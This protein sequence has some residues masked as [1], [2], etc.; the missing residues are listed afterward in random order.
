MEA[1]VFWLN[2]PSIHQAP[3]LRAAAALWPG[4]VVAV[5]EA[6][7][8][9]ARKSQGWQRPDFAPARLVVE[10]SRAQRRELVRQYATA[11]S[12]HIFS[13]LHAYPE[14]ARA[15]RQVSRSEALL[16]VFAEP[17]RHND[18]LKALLRRLRYAALALRWRRRLDFL[19]ATGELGVRWYTGQGFPAERAYPFGYFV[20][21]DRAKDSRQDLDDPWAGEPGETKL[22]FVGQLIPR[23]GVDLLLHALA[24]LSSRAWR[25]CFVGQ[26]TDS[27]RLTTLADDLGL[28]A[29]VHWQGSLPNDAVRAW[30][31]EADTLILPSRYDGWGAVVNEALALGTPV[32]VSDAC[33]AADLVGDPR[34]GR[35]FQAG[36]VDSLCE[37]LQDVL[38]S[39][40]LSAQ[41]RAAI[42][43]WALGAIAPEAAARYLLAIIAHVQARGA[44]PVAPWRGV[45]SPTPL[46][47]GDEVLVRRE[48]RE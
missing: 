46:A 45:P 40:G 28:A 12:V 31:A 48:G 7:I 36:S 37:A 2:S 33:G 27:E 18:G 4:E 42:R 24:R 1:L 8:S 29:R 43:N 13:G 23:K 38:D 34:R 17:A 21:N 16:G 11:G 3:L 5:A 30:M 44:R 19:L 39:P 26:G 32:V 41:R 47:A 10:P 14:T 22:L 6:D 35:V 25:L 20:A 9:S 15:L